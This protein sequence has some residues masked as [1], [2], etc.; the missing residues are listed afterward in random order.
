MRAFD[1]SLALLPPPISSEVRQGG[2]GVGWGGYTPLSERKVAGDPRVARVKVSVIPA[3]WYQ[4]FEIP[5]TMLPK[6]ADG[7]AG[8][9]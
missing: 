2:V 1:R 3:G 4:K 9:G 6:Q 7:S 8:C 5:R